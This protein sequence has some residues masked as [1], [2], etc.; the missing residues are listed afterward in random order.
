MFRYL[1]RVRSIKNNNNEKK[2]LIFII[3]IVLP[4]TTDSIIIIIMYVV[5]QKKDFD[6]EFKTCQS[7]KPTCYVNVYVK[8]VISSISTNIFVIL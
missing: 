3:I 1:E 6:N 4:G 7:C 5:F 2:K 8:I